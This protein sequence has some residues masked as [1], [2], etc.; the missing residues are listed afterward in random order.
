[1]FLGSLKDLFNLRPGRTH[2]LEHVIELSSEQ[3][4]QTRPQRYDRNRHE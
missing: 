3:P 1:G 4:F 2:L